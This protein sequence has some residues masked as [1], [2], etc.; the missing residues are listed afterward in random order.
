MFIEKYFK[1]H[2]RLMS[3]EEILQ[4]VTI[5]GN[6]V[7][8]PPGQL[9]RSLYMDVAKRLN[10]IGGQWKG[11][12]IAGFVFP[13]D[14]SDLI[15][16]ISGGQKIN[17]KKEFQFFGTPDAR[18]DMLVADAFIEVGHKIL[19][20]S[21]G[22]GAIVKAV[23]RRFP[24]V[25]V[26]CYELMETNRTILSGIKNARILGNDFLSN[27]LEPGIY[28][29]ILANPPFSKNQD[30]DHIIEMF[31]LLKPGGR[32]VSIASQHWKTSKNKKETEFRYWLEDRGADVQDIPAG[33][34]K[35]SGAGVGAVTITLEKPFVQ[36]D[37]AE[38]ELAFAVAF[39]QTELF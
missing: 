33:V 27:G 6:V 14:P 7:K 35:E 19:E 22:Q 16:K 39:D 29:R 5:T 31:R 18:A 30:I 17:L 21:A 25:T 13:S 26:D 12:K 32:L 24:S 23:L 15:Q 4:R 8:L 2:G 20:P 28:D 3:A 34:F 36:A 38:C 1:S 10:G 9:D 37:E 11:G